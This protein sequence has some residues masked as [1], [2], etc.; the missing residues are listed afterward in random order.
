M[1]NVGGG[2]GEFVIINMNEIRRKINEIQKF[3]GRNARK[4]FSIE[5][6]SFA[7]LPPPNELTPTEISD[8]PI[9]NTTVPVTTDGKNLLSG[10]K[11]A[12]ST[13]SNIPPIIEAPIKA[14]QPIKPPPIILATLLN[15]PIKPELVP[16]ITG[17]FPPIGPIANN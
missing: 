5:P 15:T 2:C 16:I 8:S 9:D 14:P 12:P 13:V 1:I 7:L 6:K 4:R 10:F 17:T 11:N 3:F